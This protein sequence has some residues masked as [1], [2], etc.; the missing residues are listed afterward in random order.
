[1]NTFE[2]SS[3]EA[4]SDKAGVDAAGNA[5]SGDDDSRVGPLVSDNDN[6]ATVRVAGGVDADLVR[7]GPSDEHRSVDLH[8]IPL[9]VRCCRQCDVLLGTDFLMRHHAH[10]SFSDGAA[11]LGFASGCAPVPAKSFSRGA[12]SV[13]SSLSFLSV[14]G[15]GEFESTF[16]D[17]T[18][19]EAVAC[20][21][22]HADGDDRP[23][24][25]LSC[26]ADAK[27]RAGPRDRLVKRHLTVFAEPRGVPE[28]PGNVDMSVPLKPDAVLPSPRSFGVPK[29]QQHVLHSWVEQAIDRGWIE[30]CSS[31]VN[32]PLFAV[33]NPHGRGWRIVLNLRAVNLISARFHQDSI[34]PPMRLCEEVADALVLSASDLADGFHQLK[35]PEADRHLTAFTVQGV[36]YQY[37]VAPMG[38]KN[39]PLVF[40]TMVNNVLRKH[41]LL[42]AVQLCAVRS[43]L[44]VKLRAVL[45]SVPDHVRVGT[46]VVYI[47]NF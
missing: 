47:D 33:P 3:S 35:L 41:G 39:V 29:R 17:V 12:S 2:S 6:I 9:P 28:R 14:V 23:A 10:M 15:D 30:K 26:H 19:T 1:M 8:V 43:Y 4:G 18:A 31:A 16:V 32:S 20:D 34:A 24:G 37:C 21:R 22:R 7:T 27:P 36:Q 11:A 44:P 5:Y 46:G 25:R 38:L 40:Q 45:R 42:G 13:G